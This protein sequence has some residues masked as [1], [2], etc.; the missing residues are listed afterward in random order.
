MRETRV[1]EEKASRSAGDGERRRVKRHDVRLLKNKTNK[2][3]NGA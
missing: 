3:K 1:K 2:K